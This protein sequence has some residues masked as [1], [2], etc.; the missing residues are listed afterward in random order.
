MNGTQLME[1]NMY[2]AKP[3]PGKFE[4]NRSQLLAQVVYNADMDG[5]NEVCSEEGFGHYALIKGKRYWYIL[6]EN[7]Q[8]FVSVDY[9]PSSEMLPEWDKVQAAYSEFVQGMDE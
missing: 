7:E 2:T 6:H 9:G 1:G 5:A 4:G 8:G 3:Y